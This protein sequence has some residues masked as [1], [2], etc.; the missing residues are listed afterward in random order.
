MPLTK[1]QYESLHKYYEDVILINRKELDRRRGEIYQTIPN[2]KDLEDAIISIS[3]E[4][5]REVIKG[6]I[7]SLDTLHTL[8][9][10]LKI[11]KQKLLEEN[12]YPVDYLETIYTCSKCQDTGYVG[13]QKCSCFKQKET[14]LLYEQTL[15]P[16]M[17]ADNNFSKLSY[18]YYEGDSRISFENAVN[19]IKLFIN[20]FSNDYQNLLFCGT[21]GVGKSFL[22]CCIAKELIDRNYQLLYF[23]SA[24]FFELSSKYS[25][26]SEITL[27]EKNDFFDNIYNCDLLILDDLGTEL[28]TKQ[29]LTQLFTLIN[30]RSLRKKPTIISTNYSIKEIQEIYSDRV[31]SRI[32]SEYKLI[33]LSGKDIR[34]LKKTMTNRKR[35]TIHD[36]SK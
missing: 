35:G 4:K 6:D 10:E 13:T 33:K 2:Y 23:S 27:A 7:D 20:S 32:S 26:N 19:R 9:S 30:E 11:Q 29:V 15:L 34:I 25:F 22:S 16:T 31:F 1:I 24:S 21:V 12:N 36:I 3:V 8:I 5:G 17:L 14:E 28:S 18:D